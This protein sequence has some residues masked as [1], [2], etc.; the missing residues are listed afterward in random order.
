M[1]LFVES[2]GRKRIQILKKMD[3]LKRQEMKQPLWDKF[4]VG[5]IKS[6]TCFI[7]FNRSINVNIC[8]IVYI[9]LPENKKRRQI[10]KKRKNQLE[11]LQCKFLLLLM[12]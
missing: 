3:L 9:L 5:N 1:Q 2:K 8:Y 4:K 7:A 12:L 11:I 10:P 6:K